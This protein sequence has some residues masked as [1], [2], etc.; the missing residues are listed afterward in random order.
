MDRPPLDL[1]AGATLVEIFGAVRR[2]LAQVIFTFFVV[3]GLLAAVVVI[4]PSQ[5]ESD[6]LMYVRLGRGALSVDPTASHSSKTVSL[7]DSRKSEV[8]S[9]ARMLESR[10]IAERAVR[11]V[12]AK[13]INR[14]RNWV[15]FFGESL[16]SMIPSLSGGPSGGDMSEE[17]LDE[18]VALEAAVER[19]YDWIHISV[20]KD[21]HTVAISSKGT[22][23]FLARSVVQAMMDEYQSFHVQ[24]HRAN[25]SL[26]FF[27][28]Q[29]V[30]SR[31]T[32][33]RTREELEKTKSELGWLSVASSEDTLRERI[34]ELELLRDQADSGY[35]ESTSH[36]KALQARLESVE[37]WVPIEVTSGI[38]TKAGQDMR[39]SLFG[40][41]MES[42]DAAAKFKQNHP[43]RQL[44]EKKVIQSKAILAKE[45]KDNTHNTEALNP[46][47]QEI[48][49]L[50]FATSAQAEGMKMKSQALAKSIQRANDD[51]KRLN[52]DAVTLAK[53]RWE[54]DIAET[55]YLTHARSLEEARLAS[56]LDKEELS[57]VSVIQPASLNLKK[58][59]PPR[60]IL[61]VIS[62]ILGGL[63]A[64]LIAIIR[65]G[66]KSSAARE[67]R[68][69]DE[70]SKSID[71]EKE[72]REHSLA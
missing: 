42:S 23:P 55:N 27:E 31:D 58:S 52:K 48:E 51:L 24:A 13:E 30:A 57:D 59:G 60:L 12:G 29:V 38:E 4:W 15:D 17:E 8:V 32:A 19:L 71:L 65:D 64:V 72:T 67:A 41:E 45:G 37:E 70:P 10:E 21:S 11:K 18:Q 40:L 34:I 16:S 2:H 62:I 1:M 28:E 14:P 36:A 9:V 20:P 39:T 46:V 56:A 49:Q 3:S 26:E 6:G 25:G 66:N 47:Y 61:L 22:D 5:F 69:L 7:M 63:S 35:A 50:Y 54:S 44:L 33:L 43:R 68:S 53:L